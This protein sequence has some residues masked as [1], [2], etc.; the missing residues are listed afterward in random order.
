[1]DIHSALPL[2]PSVRSAF[3]HVF[4]GAVFAV[5][6]TQSPLY[7]ANQNAYLLHGVADGGMGRLS[8]DWMANTVDPCP[9]FSTLIELTY[10]HASPALFHLYQVLLAGVFVFSVIGVAARAWG[11][12]RSWREYVPLLVIATALWSPAFHWLS[13]ATLGVPLNLTL[14]SGVAYQ[15]IVGY[16]FQP[17]AF[18]VFLIASILAF[19]CGRP[20]LAVL[21]ACSAA[22]FHATYLLSA[23]SL[24]AAYVAIV[25]FHDRELRKSLTLG[26]LGLVLV[27]PTVVY[28]YLS[29]SMSASVVQEAALTL[30]V[31]DRINHHADVGVWLRDKT[32]WLQIAIVLATLVAIRAKKR[33]WTILAVPLAVGTLLTIVQVLTQS[34]SLAVLFPWRVSAFLVPTCV[35]LLAGGLLAALRDRC[36][37]AWRGRAR[38][39]AVATGLALAFFFVH[40]AATTWGRFEEHRSRDFVPMFEH[41]RSS[42]RAG[43][44]YL[45][46]L[47]L[48]RF[49]LETGAPTFV[50]RKTHPYQPREVVEWGRRT[51]LARGFAAADPR[52]KCD[53]LRQLS[54]TEGVTHVVLDLDRGDLDCRFAETVF[55]DEHYAVYRIAAGR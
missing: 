5:S 51:T 34:K 38:A 11:L 36:A 28:S 9:V 43:E 8:E 50:D 47:E 24:I 45:I 12:D 22:T 48:E 2:R 40:G 3:R 14:Q 29:F 6:Y 10:A 31:E 37:E 25:A 41:V 46:P 49:R 55:R 54:S 52:G 16:V 26:L 21:C 20:L 53:R 7:S 15:S 35:V 44:V 32:S 23:A 30:L 4:L 17:N 13:T 18:G 19:L 27:A 33:L 42:V 39:L 1:M